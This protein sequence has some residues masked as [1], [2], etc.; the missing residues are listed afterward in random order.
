MTGLT[1]VFDLAPFIQLIGYRLEDFGDGWVE[2]SLIVE[3]RHR[4]Q[5]GFVHAG[6]LTTMADHTAGG[7]ASTQVEEGTSVLTAELGIQLLRPAAG[8]HLSCRAEVV[9]SGRSL[10]F[11]Q[12][13]VRCDGSHVARLHATMAVVPRSLA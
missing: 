9:K 1:D 10:I 8:D 5:H 12:A 6:V 4:Q 13:D 11:T 2:T 7:A 3:D